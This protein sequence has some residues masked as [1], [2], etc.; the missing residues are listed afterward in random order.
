MKNLRPGDVYVDVYGG[1]N[2]LVIVVDREKSSQSHRDL[3]LFYC[4]NRNPH[5]VWEFE[6]EHLF[7]DL[8]EV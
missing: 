5:F 7:H 8:K 1:K 6:S 4:P 2:N 3:I